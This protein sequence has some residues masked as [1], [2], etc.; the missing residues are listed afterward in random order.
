MHFPYKFKNLSCKFFVDFEFM[1][2]FWGKSTPDNASIF[3][4]GIFIAQWFR[5]S[6][7]FFNKDIFSVE[8]SQYFA[9]FNAIVNGNFYI[10]ISDSCLYR[11]AL[12]CFSHVRL[13]G[14][15]WTV[16][17]QAPLSMG[18]SGQEYWNGLPFPS[19]THR[20]IFSLYLLIFVFSFLTFP[21][22]SYIKIIILFCIIIIHIYKVGCR[23]I[24][25]L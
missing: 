23:F 9:C 20:S 12:S 13:L 1:D 19:P 17:C 5:P 25:V 16:A 22:F 15:P 4:Y 8:F 10:K 24:Y 6:E 18:L 21:W 2:E 11:E 7:C 3:Q 14:T